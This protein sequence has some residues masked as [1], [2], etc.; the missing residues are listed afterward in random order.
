M[1]FYLKGIEKEEQSVI[2]S[3]EYNDEGAWIP[4]EDICKKEDPSTYNKAICGNWKPNDV[5]TDSEMLKEEQPITKY[6]VG[7]EVYIDSSSSYE[8]WR[9]RYY[10]KVTRIERISD[11][12]PGMPYLLENVPSFWS[13][14]LLVPAPGSKD[15][16]KLEMISEKSFSEIK[17]GDYV[18]VCSYIDSNIWC[19][20]NHELCGKWWK[21][22]N[23][24]SHGLQIGKETQKLVGRANV[25]IAYKSVVPDGI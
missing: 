8:H 23:R 16:G 5:S 15:P 10:G 14:D 20:F 9:R 19:V 18:L 2:V 25:V 4:Y 11:S 12:I 7:D 21:V 22:N 1:E 24:S 17:I 3:S 13:A 6:K